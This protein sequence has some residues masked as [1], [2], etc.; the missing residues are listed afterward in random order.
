MKKIVT[1]CCIILTGIAWGQQNAKEE[2][3]LAI[4][5]FFDGFH[6]QD[7]LALQKS[8]SDAVVLQTISKD[9]LGS[10]VVRSESFQNFA[11]G[12]A[13]IPKE[14][15]F[16]EKLTGFNIQIDGNMANAWVSYEFW[17]KG[18]FHHCGVNSFQLVKYDDTWKIVYLIDTRRKE[19]C[20]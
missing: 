15:S 19:K 4:E 7:T 10:T 13:S 11:K 18:E 14:I 9:S 17:L 2:V 12:I 6:K 5:H 8:V 16:Q 3:Q 20:E 1:L